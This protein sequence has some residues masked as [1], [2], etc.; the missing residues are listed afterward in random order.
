MISTCKAQSRSLLLFGD[1]RS[2]EAARVQMLTLLSS[3]AGTLK[4][5]LVYLFCNVYFTKV[6][7]KMPELGPFL[8]SFFSYIF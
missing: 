2:L 7:A 8:S 1:H 6:L 4:R 5:A 3:S